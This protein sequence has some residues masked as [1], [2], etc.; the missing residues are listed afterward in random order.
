[1]LLQ[2]AIT[3]TV[4]LS[5]V[6]AAAASLDKRIV[7]GEDAKD[8]EFPFLVSITGTKGICGGTLLDGTTVLTA[9]HCIWG[10]VSV[11]AGSLVSLPLPP[12]SRKPN[13]TSI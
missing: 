8:G 6:S 9:A 12:N 11:R 13:S 7:G 2:A 5:A 3:L 4:A 10:T 1:M